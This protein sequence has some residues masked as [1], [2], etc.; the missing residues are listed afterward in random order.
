[1]GVLLLLLSASFRNTSVNGREPRQRIELIRLI[2]GFE[3]FVLIYFQAIGL[4]VD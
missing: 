1:M 3:V 2:A 4:G